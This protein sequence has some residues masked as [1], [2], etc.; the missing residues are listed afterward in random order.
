M[1]LDNQTA[2]AAVPHHLPGQL[3]TALAVAW[4][5][6]AIWRTVAYGSAQFAIVLAFG[7]FNL[8][9]VSRVVF[10]GKRAA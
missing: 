5:G 6:L 8:A 9:V 7:L 3:A 1:P 4:A 2:P 10:P